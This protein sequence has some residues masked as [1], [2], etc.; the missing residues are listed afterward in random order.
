[1]V[2]E[3]SA[4]ARRH[5]AG[6]LREAAQADAALHAVL[7]RD[8]PGRHDVLDALW[9]RAHPLMES[10]AG[11]PDPAAELPSLQAAVYSRARSA[12]SA[13]DDDERLAALQRTLGRD[14][15][16]LDELLEQ[17]PAPLNA[18]ETG[19]LP[20]ARVRKVPLSVLCA[21]SGRP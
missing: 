14:T 11:R 13:S 15:A 6:H 3:S 5:R 12:E 4:E 7:R 18:A 8:Y 1:M 21:V 20:S 17:Y 16:D 9:W 10:P 19:P 2:F